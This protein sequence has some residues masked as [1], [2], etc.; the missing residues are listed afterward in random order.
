MRHVLTDREDLTGSLVAGHTRQLVGNGAVLDRQIRMTDA[1]GG[2]TYEDIA[3]PR[4]FQDEIVSH[5]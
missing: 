4:I 1:T 5:L 3:T 2:H